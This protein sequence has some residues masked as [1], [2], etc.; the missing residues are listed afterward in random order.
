MEV[1]IEEDEE[2]AEAEEEEEEEPEEDVREGAHEP[3]QEEPE[4]QPGATQHAPAQERAAESE[5]K[6]A[7]PTPKSLLTKRKG[8]RDWLSF[9][10]ER[11]MGEKRIVRGNG[12]RAA[13]AWRC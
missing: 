3:V 6:A 9:A 12:A 2:E 10:Q 11:L 1:E 8:N 4:E 7:A 5:P 13:R